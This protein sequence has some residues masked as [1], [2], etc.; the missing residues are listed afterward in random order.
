[1]VTPVPRGPAGLERRR[2]TCTPTCA[3]CSS[4]TYGVVV[5]HE[6]VLRIVADDRPACTLA[7]ADEVRRALGTPE[8]QAEVER[9]VLPARARAAATPLGDRRAD[10]GGARGVRVVR[11]LQGPRRGVRAADLPV[12]LAQGAPPGGFLA[13]VLTHDPG[14]Y[15]KRL[16]LDDARQF[17]IAVLGLDVNASDEAYRVERVGAVRRAAARRSSAAPRA[18]RRPCR[19]CPTAAPTAS[20]W[21]WPRSRASATAEVDRIVAGRPYAL[22]RRLLAPRPGRPGRWSS[23]W[24]WPGRSTRC[25]ASASPVAGPPPR[26]GHPARPAAAGR[27]ARPVGARAAGRAPRSSRR[28][29]RP[30]HRAAARGGRPASGVD[31]RERAA[32]A[33]PGG[34]RGRAG[35]RA[36]DP[37]R[38]STSATR[39][40]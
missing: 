10:L 25:T 28:L 24:C 12:G 38:P 11:V 14:M 21:R 20:G 29:G 26:P 36:A 9:V 18:R 37:A 31:V 22:A 16:I 35:R 40:R 15:P 4:E 1:M 23:G 2:A 34:P 32:R 27:R 33:V 30:E 3:R 5:F 13:G 39:P 6:Q 8:G 7:E 19:A 17:G